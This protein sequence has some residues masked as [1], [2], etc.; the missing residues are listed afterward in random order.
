[1]LPAV[2]KTYEDHSTD[3]HFCFVFHCDECG[4]IWE[5]EIYPFSM[6]DTPSE[7]EGEKNARALLWKAEHD[8]SYERANTDA[9]LNFNKCHI[10]GRRVCNDC[11]SE[12]E[13]TCLACEKE[14]RIERK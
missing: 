13:A 9:M 7:N 3:R 8:A 1:M 5:S 14:K 6:R 10:C 2:T 4:V 12:F 11:F